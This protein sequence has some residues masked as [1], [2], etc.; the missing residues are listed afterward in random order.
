[1]YNINTKGT[2]CMKYD[3]LLNELTQDKKGILTTKDAVANGVTKPVF[4][5]FIKNI[6][7]QIQHIAQAIDHLKAQQANACPFIGGF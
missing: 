2:I 6:W 3:T 7:K 5:R 1:M 4:Q